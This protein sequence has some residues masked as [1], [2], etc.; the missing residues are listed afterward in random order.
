MF[1]LA[2][3]YGQVPER[4][5]PIHASSCVAGYTPQ[6]ASLSQSRFFVGWCRRLVPRQ[7]GLKGGEQPSFLSFRSG[8][9]SLN[10]RGR[11]NRRGHF[12]HF[13]Q[14]RLVEADD[15]GGTAAR[16]AGWLAA[17]AIREVAAAAIPEAADV[18]SQAA[19]AGVGATLGQ[20]AVAVPAHRVS[21][22]AW[23]G[24]FV[25]ASA[26][27]LGEP[28]VP[29]VQLL[30]AVAGMPTNMPVRTVVAPQ[31]STAAK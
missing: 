2:K 18:V 15:V 4:T 8:R 25:A 16:V 19:R 22:A 7:Q 31:R 14:S 24:C 17:S 30:T 28:V 26:I 13:V 11:F 12:R 1:R 27:G 9:S 29:R 5:C 3:K 21:I 23:H 6:G 20:P 10:A